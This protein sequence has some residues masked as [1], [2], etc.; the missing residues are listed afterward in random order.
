MYMV[1]FSVNMWL[2]GLH[3]QHVL[4]GNGRDPNVSKVTFSTC[5]KGVMVSSWQVA[6]LE[7]LQKVSQGHDGEG[8]LG[9]IL[10]HFVLAVTCC[11]SVSFNDQKIEFTPS[12]NTKRSFPGAHGICKGLSY[13]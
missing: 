7:E 10:M 12:E 1:Q 6:L 3:P 8:M 9:C 11:C 5:Q 2:I 4:T 13:L